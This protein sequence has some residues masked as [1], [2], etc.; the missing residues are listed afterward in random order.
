[1]KALK[2]FNRNLSAKA[3]I[4]ITVLALMIIGLLT[5]LVSPFLL[6]WVSWDL[7]WK[8]G[9]TGLTATIVFFLAW[10][11]IYNSVSAT[12]KAIDHE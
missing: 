11:I 8:V 3:K 5:F 2:I 10:W 6:I 9:A 12:T 4:L 7:A 1:M